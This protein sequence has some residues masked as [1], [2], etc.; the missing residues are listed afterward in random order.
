MTQ[1]RQVHLQGG[2]QRLCNP[3]RRTTL[4]EEAEVGEEAEA[5]ERKLYTRDR[6][7][8]HVKTCFAAQ[9]PWYATHQC[10]SIETLA[11]LMEVG[12]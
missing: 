10:P 9:K 12:V 1:K 11:C 2:L 3:C 4:G 8:D 6:F 7:L 5:N